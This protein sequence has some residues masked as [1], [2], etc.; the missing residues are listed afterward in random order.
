MVI[1]K[2]FLDDLTRRAKA[3]PRLRMNLDL[4]NSAEDSSQSMLNAIE[5]GTVILECKDGKWKPLGEEVVMNTRGPGY[6]CRNGSPDRW[7][8]RV[9]P[10]MRPPTDVTAH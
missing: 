8:S 2:A 10:A 7:G 6:S 5:P 1:D 4:R 9:K 3:S